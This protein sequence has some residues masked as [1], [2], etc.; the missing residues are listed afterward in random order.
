LLSWK[1]FRIL[2]KL[3]S[4]LGSHLEHQLPFRHQ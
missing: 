4:K 2:D 3:A 1:S